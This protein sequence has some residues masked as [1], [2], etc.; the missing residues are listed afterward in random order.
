M[1]CIHKNVDYEGKTVGCY[2]IL[3]FHEM[4]IFPSGQKQP[5]WKVECILC[6]TVK[7]LSYTKIIGKMQHGCSS[8][9]KDRFCGSNSFNW[10]DSNIE[11]I[12]SMYFL[13][14]KK[15]AEKRNITFDITREFLDNL[16]INQNKKCVYTGYTLYF[17]NTKIRGTASL[18]RIDSKIGYIENNVQWVHK[19]VNTIKWDLSHDKFLEICKTI[20]E[21]FKK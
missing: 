4:R 12:P 7:S 17:G 3:K 16:Y 15:S 2:K 6:N 13:K 18:D 19:D 1:N 20:T 5:Y 10:K 21:N 11:N 9:V 8:C 14:L